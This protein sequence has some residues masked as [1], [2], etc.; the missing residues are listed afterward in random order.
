MTRSFEILFTVIVVT[1]TLIAVGMAIRDIAE[2]DNNLHECKEVWSGVYNP[3]FKTCRTQDG[4][5]VH[6]FNSEAE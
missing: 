3:N 2:T 5:V 6:N 1:I 4:K